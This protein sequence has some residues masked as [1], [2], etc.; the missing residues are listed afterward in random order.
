MEGLKRSEPKSRPKE[1]QEKISSRLPSVT[2]KLTNL[3]R[4]FK[5]KKRLGRGT[6]IFSSDG[7]QA[8]RQHSK[9]W[10]EK[11]RF[12]DERRRVRKRFGDRAW[13]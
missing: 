5:A 3:A 2:I 6:S 13:S 10:E 11:N 8:K 7:T 4:E 9:V 1:A 12:K